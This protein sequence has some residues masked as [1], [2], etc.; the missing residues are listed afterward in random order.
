M[1]AKVHASHILVKTEPEANVVLYDVTH[2]KLFED[3]AKEMSICPSA[4]KGGDLGW[5]TKGRMVK[6]TETNV[7][8]NTPCTTAAHDMENGISSG[9]KF[10]KMIGI[11]F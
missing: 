9:I 1:A 11:N 4:K 5:F 3:V 8:S 10:L 7:P 2:G 6:R